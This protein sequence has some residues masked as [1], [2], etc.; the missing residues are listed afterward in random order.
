MAPITPATPSELGAYLRRI[1][2]AGTPRPEFRTLAELHRLHLTSIA[3][4]A[5]DV[6]L[7]RPVTLDPRDAFAKLVLSARGGWCY[8]MNG[9][10]AWMLEAIGFH[11]T[12]V[13]GTVE[14]QVGDATGRGNHL[15][16][17]VELDRTYVADVG[18]G[19]GPQE[20][21]PLVDG[22][23]EQQGCRYR[24]GLLDGGWWRLGNETINDASAFDF[25]TEP[26]ELT[27]LE[28]TSQQLQSEPTSPF[29][30]NAVVAI[31]VSGGYDI[32]RGRVLT[33]VRPPTSTR[34]R[35]ASAESYAALL[36]DRFGIDLA[37]SATL[38]PRIVARHQEL[39]G[40]DDP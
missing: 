7:G 40:R 9:L 24:L 3:Y 30:Q 18:F 27:R 36:R 32:L 17:L 2:Y 35:I 4:D 14:R 29:V 20:P 22:T 31:C 34:I 38:W 10:F 26:A 1:G 33:E 16:L 5:L 8:E 15:V 28:A 6:Q 25:R 19:E 21:F 39:F 12:R 37:E 11:V 13:A 23:F